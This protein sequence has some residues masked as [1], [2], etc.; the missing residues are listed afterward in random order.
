MST[1]LNAMVY[2]E[3]TPV[4]FAASGGGIQFTYANPEDSNESAHPHNLTSSLVF[5]M[6]NKFLLNRDH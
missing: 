5:R 3:G 1:A 2:A 4:I 6:K